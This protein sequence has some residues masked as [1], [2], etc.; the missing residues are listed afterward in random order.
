[1]KARGVPE[2]VEARA[3]MRVEKVWR[4]GPEKRAWRG[5]EGREVVAIV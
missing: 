1:M 4:R 3:I 5:R 2:G